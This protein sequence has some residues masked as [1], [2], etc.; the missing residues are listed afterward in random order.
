MPPNSFREV[1]R[2]GWPFTVVLGLVALLVTYLPW[3]SLGP[4]SWIDW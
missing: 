3:I 2:V 1:F 4:V